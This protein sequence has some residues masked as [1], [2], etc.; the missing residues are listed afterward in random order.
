M[1]MTPNIG[2]TLP[3]INSYG[4]G[5]PL[6]TDLSILDAVFGGT[7]SIKALSVTGN[8]TVN[9]TVTAGSFAGLNGAF[10]LQSTLLGQPNGIAQLNSNG[11]IPP[12]LLSSSAL[13]TVPFSATPSFNAANAGAFDITLTGDVT[14]STF[15]NGAS[16]GPLV[17]FRIVQDS[18]GG[19][20]FAWPANVRNAGAVSTNA[21]A[22][23]VQLFLLQTDGSLDALAPIMYS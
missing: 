11:L 13:L 17:A 14:A 18:N 16:G 1:A 8:V 22:R 21:N 5:N 19:H 9:G 23:S 4:W 2:L 20:A 12:S 7:T 6:N 10:F 15:I 3:A